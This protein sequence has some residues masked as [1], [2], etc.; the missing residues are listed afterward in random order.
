MFVTSEIAGADLLKPPN[1]NLFHTNDAEIEIL[2]ALE[3]KE[4]VER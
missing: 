3:Q 1:Q 2:Y 4:N